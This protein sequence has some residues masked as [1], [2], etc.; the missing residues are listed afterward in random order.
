[1]KILI[2]EKTNWKYILIVMMSVLIALGGF[3]VYLIYFEKEIISLMK[4]SEIK[5]TYKVIKTNY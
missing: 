4:F 3:F 2:K 1:M 5:K